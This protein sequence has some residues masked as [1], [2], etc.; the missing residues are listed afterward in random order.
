MSE[1]WDSLAVLLAIGAFYYRVSRDIG[2]LRERMAKI[3][4]MIEGAFQ[5]AK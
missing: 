5:R 4:G 3:E 2:D 1:Y